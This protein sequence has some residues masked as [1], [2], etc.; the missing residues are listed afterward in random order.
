MTLSTPE[1]TKQLGYGSD[2]QPVEDAERILTNN[3]SEL[4]SLTGSKLKRRILQL[5]L[6]DEE[7][8]DRFKGM[9]IR[10]ATA[11]GKAARAILA[12]LNQD[13]NDISVLAVG[14]VNLPIKLEQTEIRSLYT[15]ALTRAATIAAERDEFGYDLEARGNQDDL[16]AALDYFNQ[17][18]NFPTPILEKMKSCSAVTGGGMHALDMIAHS[19][20]RQITDHCDETTQKPSSVGALVHP[21][22]SFGTWHE[23]VKRATGNERLARIDNISVKQENGFHFTPGQIHE[24]YES[25]TGNDQETIYITPTGN[26]SGTTMSPDQLYGTCTAILQGNPNATIVLDVVYIRTLTPEKAQAL[27]AKIN[28]NEDLLNRIIFVESFS[29]THGTTGERVGIYFSANPELIKPI[30]NTNATITAGNGRFRSALLGVLAKDEEFEAARPI[31]HQFWKDEKAGLFQRLIE[32][33]DYP[34]LFSTNQCHYPKGSETLKEEGS[35]YVF[36]KLNED[37]DALKPIIQ[38]EK[39]V[40]KKLA[41][42]LALQT[43]LVGVVQ[44]L[45]GAWYARY[46]VG[47]LTERTFSESSEK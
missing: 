3:E 26:P 12:L 27:F 43:G 22:S 32:S 19:A 47:C 11:A 1:I 23:L 17:W 2:T 4:S 25:N 24:L 45:D 9:F 42:E 14:D 6:Q 16:N 28:A 7:I 18:Y 35:L 34:E 8:D 29:K 37:S 46:A 20:V 36:L 41:V 39:G 21:S 30:Q 33:R 13:P 5:A 10:C 15:S 44:N 31:L 40:G 38:K